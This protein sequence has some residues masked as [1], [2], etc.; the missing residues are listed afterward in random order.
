MSSSSPDPPLQS[1]LEGFEARF[2]DA[3]HRVARPRGTEAPL[4]QRRRSERGRA[5]GA[6]GAFGAEEQVCARS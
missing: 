1:N 4:V 6:L 2:S 3:W 5:S